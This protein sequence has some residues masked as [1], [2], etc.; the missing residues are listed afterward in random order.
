M[1][2]NTLFGTRISKHYRITYLSHT[3][4]QTW[5]CVHEW[6][7]VRDRVR[8]SVNVSIPVYVCVWMCMCVSEWERGVHNSSLRIRSPATHWHHYTIGATRKSA[9][10]RTGTQIQHTGSELTPTQQYLVTATQ[11]GENKVSMWLPASLLSEIRV[12]KPM[13]SFTAC[14]LLLFPSNLPV[15]SGVFGCDAIS[16]CNC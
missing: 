4:I 8:D 12:W 10:I 15:Q 14:K 13:S 5:V 1:Q 16:R 11:F 9:A 6:E 2:T 7:R 3:H